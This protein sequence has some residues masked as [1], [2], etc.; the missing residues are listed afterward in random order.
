MA[1]FGYQPDKGT[2]PC[3]NPDREIIVEEQDDIVDMS[4]TGR[5]LLIA[6]WMWLCAGKA[7]LY[8]AV[9]AVF[10][11]YSIIGVMCQ[12]SMFK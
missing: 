3:C 8:A 7:Q 12:R 6:R 4:Y 11:T 9:V 1:H 10:A 5:G 2:H